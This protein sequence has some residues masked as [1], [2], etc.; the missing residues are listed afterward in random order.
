MFGVCEHN[1]SSD[2]GD[3]KINEIVYLINSE[4]QKPNK[5]TFKFETPSEFLRWE[6]DKITLGST[7]I[8]SYSKL[9]YRK[10][11]IVRLSHNPT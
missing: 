10:G 7:T 9:S 6:E 1:F 8:I 4:T 11:D 3:N 2:G 5:I